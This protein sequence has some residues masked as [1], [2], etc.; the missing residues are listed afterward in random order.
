[1]EWPDDSWALSRLIGYEATRVLASICC[2]VAT[3]GFVAGGTGILLR[4]DWWRPLVVGSAVFSAV[5]FILFWDGEKRR[6]ANQG[7]V[8]VLINMAILFVVLIIQ[9]PDF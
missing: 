8:D 9:W 3:I 5:L 2:V 4:L 1:M 7:G 6:L